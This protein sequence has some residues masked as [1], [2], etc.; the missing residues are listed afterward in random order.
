MTITRGPRYAAWLFGTAAAF[1]AAVAFGMLA[2]RPQLSAWFGLDPATGSNAVLANLSAAL[3]AVF[4]YAYARAALDPLRFRRYIELGMLG[5]LLV[6]PAAVT[7]WLQGE[8]G[9]QLPLLACGDLLYALLFWDYLRASQRQ[10]P[11]WR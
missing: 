8:T 3:I 2:L 9:W 7:P 6:F 10:R 1:N 4:G 5:K 11:D